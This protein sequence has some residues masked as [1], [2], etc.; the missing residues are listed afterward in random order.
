MDIP[1]YTVEDQTSEVKG[2]VHCNLLLPLPMVLD[3]MC[4]LN[5]DM[6]L[7]MDYETDNGKDDVIDSSNNE[8][9]MSSDKESCTAIRT[10]QQTRQ[11]LDHTAIED[12]TAAEEIV[13]PPALNDTV[14]IV[15][16][17]EQEIDRHSVPEKNSS[18]SDESSF[19]G[20]GSVGTHSTPLTLWKPVREYNVP[21]QYDGF[22][23]GP[24]KQQNAILEK[25]FIG[26]IY[27]INV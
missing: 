12:N 11:K 21:K 26:R 18:Q 4:P 9:E 19:D 17:S 25:Q 22:I 16:P 20:D 10:H 15:D 23:L 8:S 1:V 27:T 24:L 14:D 5:P 2:T 7:K 13:D 6:S 3:W